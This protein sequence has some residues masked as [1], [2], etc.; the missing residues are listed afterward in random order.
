[1]AKDNP[2]GSLGLGQMGSERSF[3]YQGGPI[4][5]ALKGL[6]TAGIM[7]AFEKSGLKGF[8]NDMGV[9]TDERTGNL[10]YQNPNS[11]APAVPPVNK[12]APSA[13]PIAPVPAAPVESAAPAAGPAPAQQSTPDIDSQVDSV[14]QTSD[15]FK[16]R[17]T[18]QDELPQQFAMGPI[19]PPQMQFPQAQIPQ[20]S[21]IGKALLNFGFA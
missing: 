18:Q 7:A 4:S 8:L 21:G 17:N 10:R 6:K 3:M 16:P 5:D 20:S 12:A 2:F 14:W 1:M 19:A 11:P 13:A 15:L 9:K